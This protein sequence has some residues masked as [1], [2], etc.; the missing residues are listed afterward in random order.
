M[1]N[2][3]LK[4]VVVI[5]GASAGVGRATALE[6]ARR[7]AHIALIARGVA[8]LKSAMEEVE[9]LGGRAIIIPA[10]V[11]DAEQVEAAAVKTEE[12]LGP[13]DVWINN[14]MVSVFSPFKEMQ[15]EE[16]RRV[17]EVTYLGYV[18]GTMAALQRMLPRNHGR[19]IQVTSALAHRSIP[20]QSAYCGAKHAIKGFTESVQTE[21]VHDRSKVRISMVALPGLNTP[22]FEW[23]KS[24]LPNKPKPVPPV[25]QP[26]LA[27][28]TIYWAS[29]HMPR[30]M[31]L[32]FPT[33]EAVLGEKFSPKLL[34]LELAKDG[35]ASQQTSEP[36]DPERP[37]NLWEP[38]PEK[39]KIHGPFSAISRKR[40]VTFYLRKNR[41]AILGTCALLAVAGGLLMRKRGNV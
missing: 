2:N 35:Y 9:D 18:Y 31:L 21:L 6:F 13:I 23:V 1:K 17:T 10:D 12:E 28:R 27:A 20:L 33:W 26:E 19:I 8:G 32:G 30:E 39:A 16:F 3:A 41:G 24:R 15:P 34:N 29:R 4:P 36:D 40:S 37:N 22:Q 25:Y 7:G 5:T 11:S 38:V 14:A